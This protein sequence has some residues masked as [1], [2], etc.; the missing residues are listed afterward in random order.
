MKKNIICFCLAV[1]LLFCTTVNATDINIGGEIK[2]RYRHNIHKIG[3]EPGFSFYELELFID[4]EINEY[5]SYYIE[6]NL[7]HADRPDPEDVWLDFHLAPD[8]S[9]F[10]GGT[11]VKIGNFHYPFGWDN[12]DNEG[13]VYGGR[14]TVNLPLIRSQ[15]VDGW[16]IRERQLGIAGNINFDFA[17]INNTLT[18]GIFNGNGSWSNS[19]GSD[20]DTK[21]DYVGRFESVFTDLNFIVGVSYLYSPKTMGA[22]VNATNT[23]H[24]RDIMRA[25]VHFKYPDVPLP[26]QDH[27][28]GGSPWVLWGEYIF[29]QHK[30]NSAVAGAN[31]NQNVEGWSIEL[32]YALKGPYDTIA[33]LRVDYY[34]PN[35]NVIRDEV[36]TFTPGFRLSFLDNSFMILEYELYHG[37]PNAPAIHNDDRITLEIAT[38]F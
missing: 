24:V 7:M 18:A 20:N 2:M 37:E 35:M 30:A 23:T 14:I 15:R 32:D 10:S 4:G 12:D 38:V 1:T 22:M 13:Y 9:A 11:G 33:F 3:S 21:K 36:C 6:Y 17:S 26:G 29:G 28:L 5:S 19:G 8:K 31:F 25:G 34:D 16:R 27:S